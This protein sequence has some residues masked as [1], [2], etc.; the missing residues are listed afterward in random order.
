MDLVVATQNGHKIREIRTLLK[1][2][3]EYDIYSLLDFPDYAPPPETG[4]TFEANA[5]LKAER[6]AKAFGKWTLADDSGLVVPALGGAPG[7]YSAR[8]AGEGAS[9]K[10]NRKKLLKE[11]EGLKGERRFAYFEC[12]IVLASPEGVRKTVTGYCE[13]MVTEEERGGNGFGYDSLFIKHDYNQTFAELGEL[14][15]NQ[16]SH[17]AKALE[18]MLI[19]FESLAQKETESMKD[20]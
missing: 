16:V 19:T 17:R 7:I 12:C 6:A 14:L 15:K 20:L 11:M 13:G 2:L 1:H 3:K 8:Y 18:K 9:D 10:D 5:H 4:E